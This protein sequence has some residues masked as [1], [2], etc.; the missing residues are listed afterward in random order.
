MAV[1]QPQLVACG[2]SPAP[3]PLATQFLRPFKT[4]S[5][6]VS[7]TALGTKL[8]VFHQS[9]SSIFALGPRRR[10]GLGACLVPQGVAVFTFDR[11]AHPPTC[12]NAIESCAA[13]VRAAALVQA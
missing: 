2:S 9:E 6:T 7:L 11:T 13:R 8:Q 4:L 5:P 10:L 3:S 12:V 1:G